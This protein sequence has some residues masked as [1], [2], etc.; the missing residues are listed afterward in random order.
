VIH[1]VID[2]LHE[3]EASARI[4]DIPD[5]SPINQQQSTAQPQITTTRSS[6]NDFHR[7]FDNNGQQQHSSSLPPPPPPPQSKST[8][9]ERL[10]KVGEGVVDMLHIA[11]G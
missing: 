1:L 10:D 4:G 9:T 7:I 2:I 5:L 11:N 8:F 6:L 3:L